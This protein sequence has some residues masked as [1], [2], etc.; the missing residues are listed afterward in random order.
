MRKVIS[1][2]YMYHILIVNRNFSN[3]DVTYLIFLYL[4]A[5][6]YII[7]VMEPVVESDFVIVYFHT[8]TSAE[9]HPPMN[10]L[11][12]VYSILDHK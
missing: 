11:R 8:Q 12:Q 7:R 4:Q 5:L 3:I 10:Y 2:L 1:K 6:L 9:N